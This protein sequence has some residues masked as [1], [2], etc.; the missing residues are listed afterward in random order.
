MTRLLVPMTVEAFVVGKP[1]LVAAINPKFNLMWPNLM[2]LGTSIEPQPFE[3]TSNMPSGVHLRWALPDSLAHGVQGQAV[4]AAVLSGGSV[5]SVTILSAGFGYDPAKPPSVMFSGGGGVGAVARAAVELDGTVTAIHVLDGGAGYEAPPTVEVGSSEEIRYPEI[6]NR[7]FI[8]RSHADDTNK[9]VTMQTWVVVSDTL[10]DNAY[11]RIVE[12]TLPLSLRSQLTSGPIS[13]ELKNALNAIG[14]PVTE[15]ATLQS[16]V[17][18]IWYIFDTAQY[19]SI[20]VRATDL[21]VL[22]NEAVSWPRISEPDPYKVKPPYKYLG[23]AWPY[24]MWDGA[25]PVS[26]ENRLTAIGPGDPTFAAAYPNS[27]SVLGFY[28]DLTDLSAGK[29]TY[30][31]AGWYADPTENPLYGEDTPEKWAERMDELRWCVKQDP[32]GYPPSSICAPVTT[33]GEASAAPELPQDVLLQGMVYGLGWTG[34]FTPYPSGVPVGKPDIAVGNTS[35]EALSALVAKKLGDPGVEDI[36]E[37]FMYDLLDLLQQPDGMIQLEQAC[38]AKMFGNRPSETIWGVAEK[39]SESAEVREDQTLGTP[40]PPE[41]SAALTRTNDLQSAYDR[42]DA[43]LRSLQWET[44]SAWFRKAIL[45]QSPLTA[46]RIHEEVFANFEAPPPFRREEAEDAGAAAAA[47]AAVPITISQIKVVIDRL[48]ILVNAAKADLATLA[49]NLD[50]AI[51]DL[52]SKVAAQMPGYEVTRNAGRS[53]WQSNDPVVLFAGD[54]VVRTF[55]FGEDDALAEGGTLPCRVTG[56]TITALTTP[57]PAYPNQTITQT[58]LQ[59]WY[60]SFP[61]GVPVPAEI[62]PLF[63]ETLLLDT[64]MGRLMAISAWELAGVPQ[65]TTEQI[66]AVAASINAIQTAPL[67]ASLHF[68]LRKQLP[69]AQEIAQEAGL[70]GVFPYKLAVDPW[71][72]PWAPIYLEWDVL[73]AASAKVPGELAICDTTSPGCTHK[74]MFDEPDFQWNTA[75]TPAVPTDKRYA[76]TGRTVITPQAPDQLATKIEEYLRTHPESPYYQQLEDAYEVIRNLQMLSQNMSGFAYS[77]TQRR[78]TLQMPVIDYFDEKLGQKVAAAIGAQNQFSPLPDNG[79]SPLRGG[80]ARIVR[81]WVVDSFGQAQRVIDE[82]QTYNPV[83]SKPLVTAG[84]PAL[85][86]LVPRIVQPGRLDM[87]WIDGTSNDGRQS[88]SDP[89]TSPICGWIVP[90][91]FDNSIMVYNSVGGPIG[92]LQ[93]LDGAFGD[94]GSGVRWLETPGTDSAVGAQ[95]SLDNPDLNPHLKGFINGILQFGAEGRMA[96]S[97][98]IITLHQTLGTIV[99]SGSAANYGNLPVLIGRP[100]ALVRAA[101]RIDLDGLPDYDESWIALKLYYTDSKFTTGGFTD[102]LFPVR[103]GDVR[104]MRDGVIG[105]F[106][107]NDYSK[108]NSKLIERPQTQSSYIQFEQRLHLK[109]DPLAPPQYVTIVADPRAPVHV[110]SDFVPEIIAALPP[111]G[112]SAALEAMDITFRVG[113]L[114]NDFNNVSLPLPADVHGNWSWLYHPSVTMWSES[115]TIQ[116]DDAIARFTQGARHINE[117]WLKLSDAIKLKQD[118]SKRRT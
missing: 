84:N 83:L 18:N 91:Y 110:V 34:P 41:V 90:N 24:P 8:C 33:E 65:P 29:I 93:L 53:Y 92:A 59:K 103:I 12:G 27:R 32:G 81:L 40:F 94:N 63:I 56:Q 106:S 105:Y 107:G 79:Y 51:T 60:G 104:Q 55:A 57:V 20:E 45:D 73:W 42:K 1:D 43:E 97:D 76:Y 17:A 48:I 78:E 37:A 3:T 77:L 67:N 6:P 68:S 50:T 109:A 28:D 72:Q 54:G 69:T 117:G 88:T 11:G 13:T 10:S 89:A 70:T 52:I 116:N 19:Y 82:G 35:A 38:H 118:Q 102:V 9:K 115:E 22:G 44:Y 95:P 99:I 74:W 80:H 7:W 112:I 101:L 46:K 111:A 2:T 5:S 98:L 61:S 14:V 16:D 64:T 26:A 85:I 113:P 75:F 114:I 49:T 86:Q 108:F 25:N 47:L 30:M 62:Q 4:C 15:N 36:L 100:M 71:S 66:T 87:D 96:L 31:V 39:Q 23:R 58:Q 21:L